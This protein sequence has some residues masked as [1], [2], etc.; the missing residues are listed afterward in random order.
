MVRALG[1][2]VRFSYL[3][4]IL[5]LSPLFFYNQLVYILRNIVSTYICVNVENMFQVET[6][7][8]TQ[9]SLTPN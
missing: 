2:L 1:S 5:S 7:A 9:A 8:P 3:F 4:L 6:D